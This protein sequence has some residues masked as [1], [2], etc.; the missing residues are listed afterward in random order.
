MREDSAFPSMASFINGAVS[1]ECILRRWEDRVEL[2][3]LDVS[4]VA[5]D[6]FQCRVGVD[7]ETIGSKSDNWSVCLVTSPELEMA[8]SLPRVVH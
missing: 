7:R 8:V 4:L 2:R 3:L 1:I 6:G 5:I